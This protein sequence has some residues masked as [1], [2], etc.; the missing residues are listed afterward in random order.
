MG[1][2]SLSGRDSSSAWLAPCLD[3]ARYYSD[4]T[5]I[6]NYVDVLADVNLLVESIHEFLNLISDFCLAV[7]YM[8]V[9][10]KQPLK[11][12]LEFR[13][14]LT[15]HF[16]I[17]CTTKHV[18]QITVCSVMF[19]MTNFPLYKT[20]QCLSHISFGSHYFWVSTIFLLLSCNIVYVFPQ[21]L[22]LDEATA[23]I[24]TET[25][26][27]IQQTIK[28]AFKDCTMLTIAHRLNTIVHCDRIIVLQDGQVSDGYNNRK[29][30]IKN[31]E[32][33]LQYLY[34]LLDGI[35]ILLS[36][37]CKTTLIGL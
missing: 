8:T 14:P 32:C 24:D 33:H 26:A 7:K 16:M 34:R 22:L 15:H 37:C 12:T 10:L 2:I 1:K 27:K 13:S 20:T 30:S 35:Y 3:I 29:Q 6:S 25:D 5:I 18:N 4:F 19:R 36:N 21:I 17:F 11:P 31:E 23:S 9:E 28:E